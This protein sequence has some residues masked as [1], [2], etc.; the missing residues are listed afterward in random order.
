M[1]PRSERASARSLASDLEVS[2]ADRQSLDLL[3][4]FGFNAFSA[5]LLYDSVNRF[6]LR[7]TDGFVGYLHSRWV[8]VALGDPV[9]KE[10]DF[11]LAAEEFAAFAAAQGKGCVFVAAGREFVDANASKRATIL[12]LGDDFIFDVRSYAPRGDAAKKVRS[13]RNKAVRLGC[14]VREYRPCLGRNPALEAAFEAVS[15]RWLRAHS[16]FTMRLL[17]L[18]LF[19]LTELKRFFW[20]D[21]DGR[22]AAFL[23]CLP[24]YARNGYLFE[25]LVRDPEAPSGATELM[26]LEAIRALRLEGAAMASFGLSPLVRVNGAANLS[27]IETAIAR[28]G[29]AAA[30]RAGRLHRLYH[31][32]KKFHTSEAEP[33]Y[34]WKFPAGIRLRDL[35]GIMSAFAS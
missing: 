34:L 10:P 29:V 16:R 15:T 35:W 8:L 30:A 18:D 1:P 19:R 26:V 14:R 4:R 5:C 12:P 24:I 32:R 9:C 17:S 31:Y 13:A 23:S 28:V 20:V 11:G 3:R 25:D 7:R 21:L 33:S 27:P 2:T 6:H 22:V